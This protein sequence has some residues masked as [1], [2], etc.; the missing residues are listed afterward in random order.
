MF[1]QRTGLVESLTTDSGATANAILGK[2]TIPADEI[3]GFR[4]GV[5]VAL[6][7][8]GSEG[9]QQEEDSVELGAIVVT[10]EAAALNAEGGVAEAA[11]KATAVAVDKVQKTVDK[12]VDKAKPVV[13]DAAKAAG[14]AINAGARATG[15]QIAKSKTMFSDFK[16][17]YDKASGK[18][19]AAKKAASGTK[20]AAGASASSTAKKG[21]TAGA[22]KANGT[23]GTSGAKKATPAAKKTAGT[24]KA[25]GAAKKATPKKQPP[26]KN[27]FEAFKEEYDKAR[28]DD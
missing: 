14:E 2:R 24:A 17:E 12:A 16:E 27:M 8:V 13:S 11:G 22:K 18:K 5:G 6:A 23:A 21:A 20:K 9:V 26:K 3:V 19:P 4:K 25:T 7:E 10:D 1:N 28:H 15:E